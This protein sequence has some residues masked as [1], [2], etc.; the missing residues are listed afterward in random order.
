MKRPFP[1]HEAGDAERRKQVGLFRYGV[2][3]DLI[4]LERGQRG[5]YPKL[6]EKAARE[7]DIPSSRRR[8]VE[9]ETLRGWLADYRRGGFEALVPKARGD[10]GA[11]RAI[12]QELADRLCEVKEQH[13]DYS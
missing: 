8:R 12:P 2:I 13:R 7:W 10:R 1:D 9:V 5:L 6:R 4:H 11:A 3:A